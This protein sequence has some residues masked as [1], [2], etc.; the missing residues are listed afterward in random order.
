[1][2][3]NLTGEHSQVSSASAKLSLQ[4]LSGVNAYVRQEYG[5]TMFH[6]KGM[7]IW[8]DVIRQGLVVGKDEAKT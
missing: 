4:D 3:L 1:M 2:S 7:H 8:N 5:L 6:L